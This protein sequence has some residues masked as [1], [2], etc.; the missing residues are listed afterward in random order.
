M[1]Q[2]RNA[3]QLRSTTSPLSDDQL[4][5]IAPSIFAAAA[6]DSRSSRY[7][8][9]PT[10]NVLAALRK[11]GFQPFSVAQTRARDESRRE[12]TKHMVRMRHASQVA[13]NVGDEIP[14]IVLVNSHDGSSS[15]QMFAGLFRL[16]CTNGLVVAA[17]TVDEIRVPHTGNVVGRVIEGAYSVVE[18]FGRVRASADAMKAIELR[19]AVQQAFGRAAIVAKYGEETAPVTVDQVLTPR[20]A[21]DAGTDLWQTFNRVQENLVRGGLR[22]RSATGRRMRTR[23]VQGISE[24]VKLNRAL[25]TLADEM[26]KLTDQH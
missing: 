18:E 23:E 4:R 14:E 12:F 22:T 6:H 11:E 7:T 5:S 20:R 26:R 13:R 19:P 21:G 24:N 15:Y 1:M 25:W 9:I 8:Y 17:G 10:V 16:L 3:T 2:L